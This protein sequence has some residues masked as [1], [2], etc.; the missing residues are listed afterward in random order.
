MEEGRRMKKLRGGATPMWGGR[1][2]YHKPAY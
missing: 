2:R 1:P